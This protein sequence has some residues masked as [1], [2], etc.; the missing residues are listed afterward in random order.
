MTIEAFIILEVP[1]SLTWSQIHKQ[2][3]ADPGVSR[4]AVAPSWILSFN[5]D[6]VV[7]IDFAPS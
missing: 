4:R 6:L 2:S 3:G 5:A 1:V 7:P